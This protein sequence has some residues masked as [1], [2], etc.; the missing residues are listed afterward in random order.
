MLDEN[1]YSK[2][3]QP[4][5]IHAS[6]RRRHY[7]TN[8]GDHVTISINN[9][10]DPRTSNYSLRLIHLYICVHVLGQIIRQENEKYSAIID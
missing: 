2:I 3:N 8:E 4:E 6:R 7:L 10:S 9:L 1:S 5:V